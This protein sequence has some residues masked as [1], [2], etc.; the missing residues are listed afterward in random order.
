MDLE[1]N[2]V[3][4]P[5]TI[6]P[7]AGIYISDFS[8]GMAVVSYSEYVKV[9]QFPDVLIA[10]SPTGYINTKGELVIPYD[11]QFYA[12]SHGNY[13]SEGLAA[14]GVDID[15]DK[16]IDYIS[17]VDKNGKEVINGYETLGNRIILNGAPFHDGY[18]VVNFD[19]VIDK[20]GNV[21]LSLEG[22]HINAV[23]EGLAAYGD[24]ST[25]KS[26]FIDLTG[27]IVIPCIYDL[28]SNF[29]E[30]LA[31]VRIKLADGVFKY[32]YVNHAGKEIIP[33][34][35]DDG[36]SYSE[37][38]VAVSKLDS[39]G[40]LKY[41]YFDTDGKQVIDFIYEEAGVFQDGL[42]SVKKGGKYGYISY[43]G[44]VV[45][46]FIYDDIYNNYDPLTMYS[47]SDMGTFIDGLAIV[48]LNGVDMFIKQ[49]DPAMHK[50]TQPTA[51][52]TDV[53]K[54]AGLSLSINGK[55]VAFSE[56]MGKPF[57]DANNRTLIPV[58]AAAESV[59]ITV[60]WND[61][62]SEITLTKEDTILVLKLGSNIAI[63][64]GNERITMDTAA[65]KKTGRT[66]LP[67]KY[68]FEAFGYKAGWNGAT[69]TV[70]ITK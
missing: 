33:V 24:A 5:D 17:Y 40:Q 55:N 34:Q 56:D 45:V 41:G 60:K 25:Q 50:Q 36:G 35:Y 39:N 3:I 51:V 46:P 65:I 52:T 13:F 37:G 14:V 53:T 2:L 7:H 9:P 4:P 64:N 70:L 43:S 32:G 31:R 67:A 12:E 66:Y 68:V 20:K 61:K 59:G 44:S 18:A 57:I 26:G 27:K 30:G 69:E 10:S 54:P 15:G 1:G 47:P 48:R 38:L 58:R 23:R 49:P 6:P 63:K 28:T 8:E 42:A 11:Y 19:T 22:G 62:T 29:S 16:S 21:V